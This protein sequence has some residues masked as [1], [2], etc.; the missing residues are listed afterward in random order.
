MEN[1]TFFHGEFLNNINVDN[2]LRNYFPEYNYK[3]VFLDV[4]AFEPILISN[5]YHFEKNGWDVYCFEA[6]TN[7]IPLLKLHR[8]NV[9]NY[10]IYDID[11]EETTFNVV[12]S[13]GWT[14]GFSAIELS[15]DISRIF[16]CNDKK[17]TQIKVPQKTLNTILETELNHITNIDILKIDVEGGELK[18]LQGLDLQ[19]YSP[20]LILLEN[21]TNDIA[22]QN[23]L[24]NFGYILHK[25]ESYNQFYIKKNF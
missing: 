23:Y 1:Y 11:K 4:G 2:I 19:K 12:E 13:N 8:K 25:Q 5:S 10:A 17:I 24:K 20:K 15:E 6:N 22:I 18:C 9:F 7:K 16:K 21:I 3:G 14:A